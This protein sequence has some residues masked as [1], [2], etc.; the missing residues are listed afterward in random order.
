M[1]F[2]NYILFSFA[3]VFVN[4]V[5]AAWAGMTEQELINQSEV[6]VKATLIGKTIVKFPGISKP[7]LLGAL[8]VDHVYKGKSQNVILL[9]LPL[10][11]P[12]VSV[13]TDILHTVGQNG[14][15]LLK[16]SEGAEGIYLADHPQRIWPL[17][18]Q[19]KLKRLL[20]TTS[21]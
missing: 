18:Q 3:L 20:A 19:T 17:D 13:S 9:S 2:I 11:P 1:K 15:W 12:N 7:S 6:I 4:P 21:Q 10:R 16:L 8:K 5:H 14:I